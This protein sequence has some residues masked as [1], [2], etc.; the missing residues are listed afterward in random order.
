MRKIK[1]WSKLSN[2]TIGKLVDAFVLGIPSTQASVFAGV[3]R[4]TSSRFFKYIR[5]Q[6]SLQ[7]Q[8]D[9]YSKLYGNIELDESYFGGRRKGMRGRGANN[10]QIVFGILERQGMVRTIIVSDVTALTLLEAIIKNTQKGSVYYTDQFKSYKSLGLFGKH[11]SINHSKEF[12][13][14]KHNHI[15]GI[16]GFWSYAK[17]FMMKYNGVSKQNFHLY[18][19]EIEWRFNQRKHKDIIKDEILKML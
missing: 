8:S 7:C 14:Q 17:K 11:H 3:H 9:S 6:I 16:E 12:R 5:E 2:K 13:R 10:K 19:K 4:N 15:N 18:M 1:K